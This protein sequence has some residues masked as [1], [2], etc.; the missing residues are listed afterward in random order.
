[1][2]HSEVSGEEDSRQC[3]GPEVE[4]MRARDRRSRQRGEGAQ[5]LLG[6]LRASTVTLGETGSTWKVSG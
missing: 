6:H 3:Q 5:V 1:M 4:G 2:G